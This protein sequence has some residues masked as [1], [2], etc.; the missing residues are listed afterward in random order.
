MER[1]LRLK[2][3]IE[4]MWTNKILKGN[5]SYWSQLY[6]RQMAKDNSQKL[7]IEK[8]TGKQSR[9]ESFAASAQLTSWANQ[10]FACGYCHMSLD[11]DKWHIEVGLPDLANKDKYHS[12]EKYRTPVEF[13]FQTKNF[14]FK[15]V[16]YLLFV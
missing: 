5:K 10:F 14:Q 4:I 2:E 3:N 11:I 8:E 12:K 7:D 15:Y 9:L 16:M 6:L 1:Q 13:G